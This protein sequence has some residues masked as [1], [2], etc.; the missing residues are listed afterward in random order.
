M[1]T[2]QKPWGTT[3]PIYEDE[4]CHVD[5]IEVIKGGFSSRHLHREKKN[6]FIVHIGS[7]VVTLFRDERD[8]VGARIVVNRDSNPLAVRAGVIHKFECEVPTI[9]TEIYTMDAGYTVAPIDRN[10]I[11]RFSKNGV[12]ND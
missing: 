4:Y 9:A 6:A 11:V 8:E 7:I 12:R 10:D 2:E 1:S 5:R 3:T